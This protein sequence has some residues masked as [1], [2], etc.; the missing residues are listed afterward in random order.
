MPN[1][2]QVSALAA[3]AV[4]AA[5]VDIY[6]ET[7]TKPL[8]FLRVI[9]ASL[10][11]AT[12]TVTV[13]H[14]GLW[15]YLPEAIAP[16]PD[17]NGTWRV[18]ATPWSP[19]GD[20]DQLER[21]EGYMFVKQ[22]YFTLSMRQETPDA[23]SE[24]EVEK[25]VLT[26]GGQFKLWAIY[27]CEPRAT[28]R[29]ES[30]RSHYGALTLTYSAHEL[31]GRFWIDGVYTDRKGRKVIGGQLRLHD[32]KKEVFHDYEAAVAAYASNAGAA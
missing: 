7:P 13:F 17:I 20:D 21:F 19:D 15:R 31:K 27:F 5:L 23:S 1:K 3:V 28:T 6:F 12:V 25:F 2:W 24:L 32:R 30:L 18:E 8:D 22:N 4:I 11:A 16:Q 26:T 14:F 29:P 9:S 10:T